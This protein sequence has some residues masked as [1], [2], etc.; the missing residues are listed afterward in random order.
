VTYPGFTPVGNAALV[1]ANVLT[2]N[3]HSQY[4]SVGEAASSPSQHG[5]GIHVYRMHVSHA[6]YAVCHI[7]QLQ[8][9]E[10][11]TGQTWL[12]LPVLQLPDL[13]SAA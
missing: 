12:R 10:R 1:V 2:C 4:C 6:V 9:L 11:T 3:K 5:K 13:D 8:A 7:M